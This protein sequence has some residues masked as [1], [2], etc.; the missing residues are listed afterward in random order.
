[1]QTVKRAFVY[2]NNRHLFNVVIKGYEKLHF[3]IL[4][5]KASCF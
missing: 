5:N 4:V 2:D 1:V 3:V